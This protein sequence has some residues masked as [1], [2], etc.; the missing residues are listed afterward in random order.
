MHFV[1][2]LDSAN[3]CAVAFALTMTLVVTNQPPT[4]AEEKTHTRILR[5]GQWA[6]LKNGWRLYNDRVGQT[7]FLMAEVD[8]TWWPAELARVE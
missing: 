4:T 8:Q 6:S 2:G 3:R 7:V 1:N 5:P